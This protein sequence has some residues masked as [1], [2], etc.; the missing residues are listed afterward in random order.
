VP[1]L[2][3]ADLLYVFLKNCRNF[4]DPARV[5]FGP[6]LAA[7]QV[8]PPYPQ[9]CIDVAIQ[10]N[11]Q[12]TT[13]KLFEVLY[14]AADRQLVHDFMLRLFRDPILPSPTSQFLGRCPLDDFLSL[15]N[16][17]EITELIEQGEDVGFTIFRGTV[18][19]IGLGD[20]YTRER[21][22]RLRH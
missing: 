18:L 9:K 5:K 12:K 11:D 20:G 4:Y 8:D 21:R 22:L 15:Q 16:F 19:T 3:V 10:M 1:N 7:I 17:L 13:E 2:G 6:F 14:L